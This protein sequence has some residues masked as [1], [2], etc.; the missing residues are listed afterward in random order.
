MICLLGRDWYWEEREIRD[1]STFTNRY[2][3]ICYHER[4]RKFSPEV[5]SSCLLI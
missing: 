4:Y 5:G 2:H 1:N 3:S